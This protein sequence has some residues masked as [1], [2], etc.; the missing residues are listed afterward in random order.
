MND[1]KDVYIFGMEEGSHSKEE[2]VTVIEVLRQ[3]VEQQ[4][5]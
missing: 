4:Q 1:T 5:F 3:I 2:L